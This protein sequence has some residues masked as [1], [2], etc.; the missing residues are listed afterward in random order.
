MPGTIARKW[1]CVQLDT[2]MNAGNFAASA[3]RGKRAGLPIE[4]PVSI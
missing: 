4:S 2:R 3:L 1:P